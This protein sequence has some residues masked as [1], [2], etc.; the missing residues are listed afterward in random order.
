MTA[1]RIGI[2]DDFANG[3]VAAAQVNCLARDPFGSGDTFNDTDGDPYTNNLNAI[4]KSES[5]SAGWSAE[6]NWDLGGAVVTSVTGYDDFSRR[7][8]LDEDAG[9]T[10]ALDN[11]RLSHVKQFSQEVR[12]ASDTD[13]DLQ[14]I[15]GLYYSTDSLKGDPAFDQSGRRD[16]N[17]LDTRTIGVF[18]NWNTH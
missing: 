18:D 5:E 11:V 16:F 3:N 6:I 4:G 2:C 13:S 14:W 8:E 9:P 15:G 1:Y 12:I 10:T 7:D 17:E